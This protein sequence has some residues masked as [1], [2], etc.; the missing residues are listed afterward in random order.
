MDDSAL[1]SVRLTP[2]GGRDA[3]MR[4]DNGLLYVRVAAPPVAGA[5]NKALVAL[6]SKSLRVAKSRIS[7]LSGGTGRE[8]T[9]RID[10][11]TVDALDA[12]LKDI[13][14]DENTEQK[15]NL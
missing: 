9:L 10:G 15:E 13:M 14:K 8:K 7:L 6:L 2:E 1:L 4:R 5:A 11:M 12:R 3:V